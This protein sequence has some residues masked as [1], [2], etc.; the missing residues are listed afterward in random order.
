[1][2]MCVIDINAVSYT[3]S[4]HFLKRVYRLLSESTHAVP[5]LNKTADEIATAGVLDAWFNAKTSPLCLLIV[6]EMDQLHIDT[7]YRVFD[8][9]RVLV[10]GMANHLH[11]L[12]TCM[13][14][15]QMKSRT[16]D[17][18]CIEAYTTS[19][20]IEILKTKWKGSSIMS[21]NVIE[22]CARKAAAVGGDLRKALNI[23]KA[24]IDLAQ[25]EKADRVTV[26]HVM[27]AIKSNG[28]SNHGTS[29]VWDGLSLNQKTLLVCIVKMQRQMRTMEWTVRAV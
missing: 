4:I 3:R 7:L 12:K 27:K 6:D 1:M 14:R 16:P 17:M 24:T 8:W 25:A 23:C 22:L 20:M 13:P 15:L 2:G 19:Q 28:T 18:L 26:T 5:S 9:Q 21:A 10:V 29:S 11:F